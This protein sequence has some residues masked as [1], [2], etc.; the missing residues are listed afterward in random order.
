M[1]PASI[2]RQESGSAIV[3]GQ[4]ADRPVADFAA[5]ARAERGTDNPPREEQRL[6]CFKETGILQKEW[7]L[8]REEYF[9]PL[10]DS[11]LGLIRLY[12]AEIRIHREI[13]RQ[14]IAKHQFGIYASAQLPRLRRRGAAAVVLPSRGGVRGQL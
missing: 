5:Q 8:F 1:R 9:V 2:T 14:R 4:R 11:D 13:Q 6:R 10:V 3:G 7:P 12:L